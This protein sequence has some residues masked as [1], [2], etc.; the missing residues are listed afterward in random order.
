MPEPVTASGD[1]L[2]NTN[3]SPRLPVVCQHLKWRLLPEEW[4]AAKEYRY[5]SR[6]WCKLKFNS[7]WWSAAHQSAHRCCCTEIMNSSVSIL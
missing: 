2:A 6:H 4:D 7:G 5:F 1:K 3:W